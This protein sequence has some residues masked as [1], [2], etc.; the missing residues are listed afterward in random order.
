[1]AVR[2][3]NSVANAL[4]TN[5]SDLTVIKCLDA[6][7]CLALARHMSANPSAG[8]NTL[9]RLDIPSNHLDSLPDAFAAV[10]AAVACNATVTELIV[11]H[12]NLGDSGVA[13]LVSSLEQNS[14]IKTLD[15]SRNHIC[16]AG[17]AAWASAQCSFLTDLDF[18]HNKLGAAGRRF[19]R[20][21]FGTECDAVDLVCSRE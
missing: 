13:K 8:A 6:A 10:A 2:C 15:V 19:S 9:T 14:S 20:E 12:N 1:M 5:P 4:Q 3:D 11:A 21:L 7:G 17:A 18:S 16:D